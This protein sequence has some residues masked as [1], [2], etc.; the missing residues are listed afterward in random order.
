M[1]SNVSMC[2]LV[3]SDGDSDPQS[4]NPNKDVGKKSDR[5]T[6]ERTRSFSTATDSSVASILSNSEMLIPDAYM[7]K[8]IQ[9][10]SQRRQRQPHSLTSRSSYGYSSKNSSMRSSRVSSLPYQGSGS[11]HVVRHHAAED[12]RSNT[13]C[14]KLN[15]NIKTASSS[16]GYSDNESNPTDNNKR[17][18]IQELRVK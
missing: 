9:V 15:L 4:H 1:G 16:F 6:G 11:L 5:S 8:D 18:S 10:V 13:G 7:P 2:G 12:E 14:N 3:A 17:M